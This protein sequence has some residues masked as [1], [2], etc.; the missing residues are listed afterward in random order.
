MELDLPM[1][2][3]STWLV[4]LAACAGAP[5]H[6]DR[7]SEIDAFER[8]MIEGT[9]RMDNAA[10]IA[11]WEDDGVALLPDMAPLVGKRAIADF[12]TKTTGA[13]PNARMVSFDMTCSG[14]EIAGDL[15]T[16]YCFEHQVVDLG[17]DKPRFDGSG[18]LLFVLHRGADGTWRLRREMWNAGR[19]PA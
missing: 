17:P 8:A 18:N 16:E 2:A 14:R 7:R 15:A 12:I 1:L 10:L 5:L 6:V 11:L 13:M 4:A 9:R 19:K 3:R